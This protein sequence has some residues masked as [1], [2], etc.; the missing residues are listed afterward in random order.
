MQRHTGRRIFDCL[1]DENGYTGGITQV[2]E[3]VAQ[4][5][6]TRRRPSSRCPI[7]LRTLMQ[8]PASHL[9]AFGFTRY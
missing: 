5:S 3:A 1:R 6:A 7:P 4:A 2:R 8:N 9:L